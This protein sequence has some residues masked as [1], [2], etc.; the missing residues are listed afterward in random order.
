M[1]T[2][3]GARSVLWLRGCL[4]R[5]R[6]SGILIMWILG[7]ALPFTT[8]NI[9]WLCNVLSLHIWRDGWRECQLA[10]SHKYQAS[11]G[12]AV[13]WLRSHT[14]RGGWCGYLAVRCHKCQNWERSCDHHR[15]DT[16]N[17]E[18]IRL[19]V[20]DDVAATRN[21]AGAQLEQ[22]VVEYQ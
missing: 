15:K 22:I 14:R 17:R 4:G 12:Y 3:C 7:G 6:I 1:W 9:C 21:H 10:P 16:A 18:H 11:A 20:D 13:P 2:P 19:N 5:G 8:I